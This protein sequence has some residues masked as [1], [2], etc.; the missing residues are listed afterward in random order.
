VKIMAENDLFAGARRYGSAG[1]PLADRM[2]PRTFDEYVG[3]DHVVGRESV[4]R[5][6][7]EKGEIQSVIFWG[8]PGTGKTTLAHIIAGV[9]GSKFISFS[10]V[11]SG[12]KDI[13][14]VV[15]TAE[16][17][18][19]LK[20]QKT[21]LFV[22]EIHRFNK[23]QQDA[24]LP[25]VERGTIILIGATTENP[26][27]EVISA[28]LSRSLVVMLQKLTE[29]DLREIIRRALADE[30]RGLGGTRIALSDEALAHM[31]TQ[32]DGDARIALNALE[33]AVA[34][35]A[36]GDDGARHIDL[37]TIE[38]ALQKKA[39]L[40]DKL[41]E[42]HYNI[43]SALHKSLRGSDPDAAL[44]WLARMLE[45]GEDPLYIAR[46]MI[47]FASEDI[48]NADP[49]ALVVA[50]AAKEAV[51]FIGMPEG[52]LALAQ[53]ALYLATA[54]KS[55]AVYTAYSK[56]RNDVN[57]KET[58]P[59]PF[60]IRNAPT[61]LMKKMGFG[62]GYEYPHDDPEGLVDQE[63][64][65]GKVWGRRYYEPTNRG[66]EATIKKRLDKWRAILEARRRKKR[67]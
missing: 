30:E 60:H 8:P 9:T 55:N 32:A 18:I 2:R 28:L 63:Y 20:G 1:R 46:R 29:D 44:Y 13:R 35:T 27:F 19:S 66:Y 56:A 33:L 31:A 40:Y 22:D 61:R 51:H 11:T 12:V 58:P 48:G 6:A 10:A 49:Q 24:F 64:L 14:E 47:R 43:I 65:A 50:V 57:S 23:A 54:P 5:K 17:N 36:P 3:Q 16:M 45:A 25:H 38:G 7:I 59:V 4:L 41:G 34:A 21:I 67:E 42:E 37:K 62:E 26:S 15:S 52:D 39:L 53:A